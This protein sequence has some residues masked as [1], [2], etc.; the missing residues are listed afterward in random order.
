MVNANE[1]NQVVLPL[2]AATALGEGIIVKLVANKAAIANVITDVVIGVTRDVCKITDTAP[3]VVGGVASVR[4]GTA[5]TEG[6]LIGTTVTTGL[7]KVIV[8]GAVGDVTQFIVGRSLEAGAAGDLVSVLLTIG[9]R[10]A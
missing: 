2:E 10:A 1:W 6:A 8:A 7:G 4:M 9:G 5:V 3:I